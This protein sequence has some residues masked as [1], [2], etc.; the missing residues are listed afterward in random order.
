MTGLVALWW[1]AAAIPAASAGAAAAVK[2]VAVFP[3]ELLDQ[4]QSD[5]LYPV[6]RPEETKR[7]S[8]LTEDL[9]A[10]LLATHAYT[11]A[12]LTPLADR[13]K[14][15]AP[16]YK[17]E[18]CLAELARQSNAGFAML[19]LVQKISDTLLSVTIQI[20]DASTG[21]VTASYS[22]GIQ[23]NT[24]EAWLRGV[25]YLVRNK[26]APEGAAP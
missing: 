3:F 8:L 7:L 6:V 26:I 15:D 20:M 1:A 17:C 19:G 12:D 10:R 14:K 18:S 4:S 9:K 5:D 16:L 23:G 22:A 2:S 11:L 25:S 24:D 21:A 13:I